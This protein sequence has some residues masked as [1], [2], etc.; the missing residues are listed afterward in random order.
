VLAASVDASAASCASTSSTAST[1]SASGASLPSGTAA[2]GRIRL[3]ASGIGPDDVA[4]TALAKR[5]EGY[6]AF[7]FKVG[8]EPE[9]DI[10]NFREIRAALGPDACIMVDANQA[11][12]PAIAAERLAALE[13]FHPY[14][15]EE[16]LA[17]DESLADWRALASGTPLALAAGENIRGA[18]DFDAAI[19]N[20][21]LR[22]IQPD[23]GKWGGISA[24]M[25]VARAAETAGLVFCPHWL[26]GGIGLAASM[27]LRAALGQAGMVEVDANPNPLRETVC[28]LPAADADADGWLALPDTPGIGVEPHLPSLARYHVAF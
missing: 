26:G 9:R 1:A 4:E 12:T 17:A 15:V 18:G 22:F 11:W 19:G 24:C 14:W 7:K 21:H 16:P 25:D 20:G 13:P 6:G 2:D 28:R 10:A 23:V 27:H 8:F 5:A 3:Y